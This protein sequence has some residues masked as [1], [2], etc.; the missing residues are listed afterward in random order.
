[1]K[2][3]R[4]QK[5]GARI[6]QMIGRRIVGTLWGLL[7]VPAALFALFAIGFCDSPY[8]CYHST[9]DY[10]GG[11]FSVI[12]PILFI[13]GAIGGWRKE[14]TTVNKVFLFLPLIALAGWAGVYFL[15]F[16]LT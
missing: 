4:V 7:A 3:P 10:I 11:T 2:R 6:A 1:M 16:S 12:T 14:N 8:G 9:T 13:L 5:N 15:L